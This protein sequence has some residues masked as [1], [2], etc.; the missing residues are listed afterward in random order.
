M[1]QSEPNNLIQNSKIEKFAYG[2]NL[3]SSYPNSIMSAVSSLDTDSD[4]RIP[5]LFHISFVHL[6]K[7][8]KSINKLFIIKF[9]WS[10]GSIKSLAFILLQNTKRQTLN[11]AYTIYKFRKIYFSNAFSFIIRVT[12]TSFI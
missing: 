11:T 1:L 8:V 4:S 10:L 2:S 5:S 7:I 12:L 3:F 6:F 9:S